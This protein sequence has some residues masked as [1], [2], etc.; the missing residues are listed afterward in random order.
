MK[1]LVNNSDKRRGLIGTILFHLLLLVIFIFYGLTYEFPPPQEGILINFGTSDQGTG[2]VQPEVSGK[3]N[4]AEEATQSSSASESG[5]NKV[6]TQEK[7]SIAV[8]EE[9]DEEKQRRIQDQKKKQDQENFKKNISDIWDTS[10][11]DGGSEGETGDKGDQGDTDG[12]KKAKSH[13]GGPSHGTGSYRLSGRS[14]LSRPKID[15][16]YKEE[17]IVVV[18]IIVDKNGNVILANPGAKGSNTSNSRLFM[19]AK[20]A[21]LKYKFNS[22]LYAP[23]EQ[24]GVIRFNFVLE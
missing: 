3:T 5:E 1:E 2:D 23:E 11:K 20:K 24:Q 7:S 19:L 6:L 13:V 12:S 10:N 22:N 18:T 15:A 4:S 21:A 14:L 17:G 9:S 8:P 16:K